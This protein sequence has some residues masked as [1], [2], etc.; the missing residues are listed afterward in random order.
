MRTFL[1]SILLCVSIGGCGGG[2]G[3]AEPPIASESPPPGEQGVR[4]SLTIASASTGASYLTHIY[5]PPA[6]AGDRTAM[7]VVY[8]LD[9]QSWF[10]PLASLAETVRGGMIVVAL[11]GIRRNQDYVPQNLCTANGGGNAAF[12]DF[13]R[14]E[15]I[16]LV[17][18]QYG[19]APKKRILFGH[20]HGGAFALYAM[21]AEVPGS[22]TFASYLAS[23]ASVSCLPDAARG[24]DAAYA[25]AHRALPVR[26]HLSYATLGNFTANQDYAGVIAARKYET[27][28]FEPR[29]YTG[30]HGGI[31][32]AVLADGTALALR[33]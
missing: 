17:E 29:A 22:H 8:A 28:T 21:Y 20:S 14:K 10:A 5:V 31:V 12:F 26:L 27:F 3:G 25:A 9:G 4:L 2:G 16:P 19:G 13:I 33:Q 32:P 7:P 23:D 24:W 1:V 30:T 6:S 18:R 11:D 15:L